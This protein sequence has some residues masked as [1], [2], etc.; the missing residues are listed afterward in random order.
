M[1]LVKLK[2]ITNGLR[3]KIKLTKNLLSKNNRFLRNSVKGIFFSSGRSH[4][5]SITVWHRHSGPKK[6]IRQVSFSN[7]SFVALV[8]SVF[9]DPVR[10]SFI[11]LNFDLEKLTFF[12]TCA[13][14]GLLPGSLLVCSSIIKEFKIGYRTKLKNMPVGSLVSNLSINNDNKCHYAKASG[15][16]AQI[17]QADFYF[18]KIKLPS[19]QVILLSNENFATFGI[20]SD[21]MVNSICL[22]KAGSSFYLGRRPI[23]RGVAMNPIDHPHGGRAPGGRLSCSPWGLP[24]KCGYKKKRKKNNL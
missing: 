24:T 13:L 1:K 10:T 2:A 19:N 5:G 20:I 16:F 7:N 15:A 17:L 18:S 4:Q 14:K 9:Y 11:T 22:G 23:V 12:R 21:S 3:H 6:L 8:I